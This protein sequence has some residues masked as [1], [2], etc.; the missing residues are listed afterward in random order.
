MGVRIIHYGVDDCHRVPVMQFAGYV[1]AE[2]QS[3]IAQLRAALQS[4]QDA[5]A[6]VMT[7][8][9]DLSPQR[10]VSIARSRTTAP[11]VLFP[12][13]TSSIFEPE[14]DLVVPALT[15]PEQW[16]SEMAELIDRT[17]DIRFRCQALRAHS[18]LLREETATA[19]K[20][21]RQE[22]MRSRMEI[23]KNR[24]IPG[25][26]RSDADSEELTG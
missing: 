25:E 19:I 18:A 26:A 11:L 17:L 22:R 6:V 14:F 4:T 10:A 13:G 9:E 20:K 1:I 12:Q 23:A 2:C 3:S 5:G 16:L 15:P 8:I 21:S 24:D 7:G